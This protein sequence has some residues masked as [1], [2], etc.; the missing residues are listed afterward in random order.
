MKKTQCFNCTNYWQGTQGV[1]CCNI[2][3]K[4]AFISRNNL[5]DKFG[6]CTKFEKSK[7]PVTPK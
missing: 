3:M 4:V 2:T 5:N 7:S 6:N 1:N